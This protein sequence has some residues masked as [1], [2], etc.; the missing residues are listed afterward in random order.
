MRKVAKFLRISQQTVSW[1]ITKAGISRKNIGNKQHTINANRFNKLDAGTAYWFGFLL[2]D[3]SIPKS[4]NRY[5]LQLALQ[6]RDRSHILKFI[7]FISYSKEPYDYFTR[8]P[9]KPKGSYM[10]KIAIDNKVL[11]SNLIKLGWRKFKSGSPISLPDKLW[12]HFFRGLIDGD[13]IVYIANLKQGRRIVIGY[14]NKHKTI[15]EWVRNKIKSLGFTSPKVRTPHNKIPRVYWQGL[16]NTAKLAS[17][18]Y[19]NV[20][21]DFLL[22]RKKSIMYNCLRHNQD[23]YDTSLRT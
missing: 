10:T 9:Y 12:R 20:N 5:R 6:R 13:G 17:L 4:K 18:M 3:G 22:D 14:C 23:K 7:K 19:K 15:V 16:L 21:S 1:H 8:T 11:I 2:C